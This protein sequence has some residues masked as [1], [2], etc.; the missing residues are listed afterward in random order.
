VRVA[1][2]CPYDLGRP[3]GG[4]D[5]TIRLVRWLGDAGVEATLIGPGTTGPQGATLLGATTVIPI[6]RS[7]AP[8]KLDPRIAGALRAALEGF[9]VV[10]VHEPLVPMV[11]TAALGVP[12][13]AKVATFH[14]NPSRLVRKAYRYGAAAMRYLLRRVD[15]FTAVS[16]VAGSAIDG[17]VDYRVIPNGIDVEAY[18][19][20]PKSE[21]RVTFIGRDDPRKGLS[22]LLDAW[23][24]VRAAVP[25]ATLHVVGAERPGTVEGVT[26]LG[27][28]AEGDKRLELAGAAVHCAPNLG[29]ESFGVV[30]LEAMASQCAVVA[31]DLEAFEYV[32]GETAMLVPPGDAV[33]LA[34]AVIGL[35]SDPNRAGTMGEA[36]R[37]RANGF[38]GAEIAAAYIAAY[39]DALSAHE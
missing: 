27:R 19:T 14:A 11:S 39:E 26:F 28:L 23:P 3:G 20:G 38:D 34:D 10:H 25:S 18:A 32:A 7:T 5:Q 22:V 9:D 1:V 24:G 29:G 31:S 12:G 15:V 21:A 6:N 35:L 13:P 4:Q 37:Q 8:V 16:P 30:V 33:A 2:V 36:A 17:V